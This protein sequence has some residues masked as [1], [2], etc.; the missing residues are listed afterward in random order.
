MS[1]ERS[2]SGLGEVG[3]VLDLFLST[4]KIWEAA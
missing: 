2:M 1:S 3:L 4:F